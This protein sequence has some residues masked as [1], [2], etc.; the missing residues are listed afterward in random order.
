MAGKFIPSKFVYFDYKAWG[1]R[2]LR[3]RES[4]DVLVMSDACQY[5][6][7]AVTTICTERINERDFSEMY[8]VCDP[9][10]FPLCRW[11]PFSCCGD[12]TDGGY[13][14]VPLKRIAERYIALH[15]IMRD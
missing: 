11:N 14:T 10:R 8:P 9:T 7:D 6:N 2:S 4:D 15:L 5:W 12:P 3:R 1:F 13:K